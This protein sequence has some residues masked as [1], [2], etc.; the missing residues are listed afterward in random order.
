MD[1][2]KSIESGI[3]D[4]TINP[5]LKLPK[6]RI[7]IKITIKAPSTR[8]LETVLI[9]RPTKSERLRNGSIFTP[10]GNDF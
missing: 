5:A 1:M 2:A 4:A 3:T 10:L 7:K 8:F 6:N 9:A